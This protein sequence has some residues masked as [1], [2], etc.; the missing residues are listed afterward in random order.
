MDSLTVSQSLSACSGGSTTST[1]S[2]TNDETYTAYLVVE[3]SINGGSY[4]EHSS[5]EDSDDFS[6]AASGSDTTTFT[7]A[8]TDGQSIIWRVSGS[9]TTSNTSATQHTTTAANHTN[10]CSQPISFSISQSL[11]ACSATG[12][13]RTSTLTIT[14]SES[15]TSYFKVE[16]ST[17]GG[18]S[19][20]T[21]NANFSL[22]GNDTDSSTFTETAS[23]GTVTWR[24]TGSDTSANFTGLSSSTAASASIDCDVNFSI[25]QALGDCSASGGTRTSTLTITN[26]ESS[27]AYFKVEKSTDGGSSYSTV[28]AN[29]SLAAGATDSSTFTETVSDGS[30]ITWR[31]TGSD[32]SA[33]FSNLTPSTASGTADCTVSLTASQTLGSCAAGASTSTFTVTNNESY[34]AYVHVEYSLDGGSTFVEHTLAE[35]S[36]NLTLAAGSSDLKDSTDSTVTLTISV[37]HGQT[38][39]WRATGSP[40]TVSTGAPTASTTESSEVSCPVIDPSVR[41]TS[42]LLYTSDAADDC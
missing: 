20:T 21:V 39:I 17:D 11:S 10:D 34:A 31:V 22:A 12:G 36:D 15:T 16:K 6:L 14:N 24:V 29:F 8:L 23:S 40:T 19:Y 30:S 3:Y 33:D 28:N 38:V 26:D 25:S 7:Q 35:D 1:L 27:T 32:T 5:G 2:I 42:C 13:N 4:V 9:P 18:S 37:A 41:N